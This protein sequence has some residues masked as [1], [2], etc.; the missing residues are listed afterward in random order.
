[1]KRNPPRQLE[2][3]T[4]MVYEDRVGGVEPYANIVKGGPVATLRG[5]DA[6]LVPVV[7]LRTL[8]HAE[9]RITL[10]SGVRHDAVMLTGFVVVDELAIERTYL[11]ADKDEVSCARELRC[12]DERGDDRL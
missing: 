6:V 2:P 5:E 8:C 4:V 3:L 9:R 12:E 10:V 11:V 1:V 7:E